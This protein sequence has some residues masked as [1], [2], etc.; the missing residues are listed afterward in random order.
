MS[1]LSAELRR[2]LGGWVLLRIVHV[3]AVVVLV[4]LVTRDCF[5]E[6]PPQPRAYE[7]EE[8]GQWTVYAFDDDRGFAFCVASAVQNS[9]TLVF[10]GTGD[11]SWRLAL[12][13]DAW[14]LRDGDNYDL[15]YIIDHEAP[16]LVTGDA[17][18]TS[19]VRFDLEGA[20]AL[21]A[22]KRGN[23]LSVIAAKRTFRFNLAGAARALGAAHDCVT[24]HRDNSEAAVQDP[25][26][27]APPPSGSRILMRRTIGP[28]K[29]E[30]SES[31]DGGAALCSVSRT[32]DRD[33]QIV[34]SALRNGHLWVVAIDARGQDWQ[35]HQGQ[36]YEIRYA[37]DDQDPVAA[38]ALGM[39]AS[40]L[41]TALGKTFAA[42]NP[43]RS[44][45]KIDFQ[46]AEGKFSFALDGVAEALDATRDCAN[47]YLGFSEVP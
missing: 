47:K 37:L 10:S 39:G 41:V 11:G 38:H 43:L 6:T 8:L 2:V 30:A 27:D 1:L 24:R 4:L 31:T 42:T 13:N 21:E 17:P 35:L 15:Q 33:V 45:H 5:A 7:V 14:R 44:G 19:M 34:V 29:L 28:W 25:F 23:Q 16:V 12:R 18:S 20:A 3:L 26:S 46:I 9:I 32:N 36:T 40:S 22:F